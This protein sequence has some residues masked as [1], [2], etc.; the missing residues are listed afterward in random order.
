[1]EWRRL[2]KRGDLG[3][4]KYEICR[5]SGD[6]RYNGRWIRPI[7]S[8][9]RHSTGFRVVTIN[10]MCYSIKSLYKFA[11]GIWYDPTQEATHGKGGPGGDTIA[12]HKPELPLW[13]PPS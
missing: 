4:E 6:V 8:Q 9:V 3:I 11:Y 13:E 7:K 10:H 2:P 1:M 12:N 5:E